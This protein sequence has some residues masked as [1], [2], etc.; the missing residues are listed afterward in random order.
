MEK[1]DI[2]SPNTLDSHFTLGYDIFDPEKHMSE[3]SYQIW[4]DKYGHNDS[5]PEDTFHRVAK[6]IAD[7]EE[8]EQL[9]SQQ[10]DRFFGLMRA[11][12]WSPAG[13][14]LAGAGTQKRVTLVNCFVNKTIED[15]MEDI[16]QANTEAAL[17]MQQG[18]GMGT[19]FSTIR[20]SGAV[21]KRTGSE[22]SGPLPFMDM[23][24]SMCGTIMSAGSRRGAM[25][26][27]LSDTHP[28]LLQ[29]IVAKQDLNRMTNFNVSILVSDAFMSAVKQDDDWY[30][31][32]EVPPINRNEDLI[33]LDFIDSK[34][35]QQYVYSK[36][37]ALDIF[38]TII[39]N[40][41]DWAE[42]GVIFIDKVNYWNNLS[43]L[44]NIRCTNPCGEQPLPPY[45]ACN[46]GAIN[47]ARLVRK[48]FQK[49]ASLNVGALCN[50]INTGM[51][52]LDN[53][54]DASLYPLEKQKQEQIDKRRT[55]L[56]YTGFADMCTQLG[57][58]Y[59][60]ERSLELADTVGLLLRDGAYQASVELAREKGSFKLFNSGE[61][62]KSPFVQQ[63]PETLKRAIQEI[64]I[65]NG[66]LLTLAP[67]GTT[68]IVY[69]NVSSSIEPN[70]M[71][72]Y[73]RNVKE[74]DG[75]W[76]T[77]TVTSYI[78]NFYEYTKQTVDNSLLQENIPFTTTDDLSVSEHVAVQATFQKYIDASISKT[79][80]CPKDMTFEDFK[81]VYLE[82]Y[83]QGCKGCTTYKPGKREAVL[84]SGEQ[85]LEDQ[86]KNAAQISKPIRENELEGV[87]YKIKWPTMQSALYMTI[88]HTIEGKPFEV[89]FNSKDARIYEWMTA[90]SLSLT[91]IFKSVDDPSFITKELKQVNSV[92]ESAWVDGKHFGSI[93]ALIAI[94]IEQHFERLG[95]IEN[96][97]VTTTEDKTVEQVKQN[98]YEFCVNCGQYQ[99][100]EQS[101]CN[102]CLNCGHSKCV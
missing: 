93:I 90:L 84:F 56:G 60:S 69:G 62:L 39:E 45:G 42:P 27:T 1:I 67:T 55:G 37:K 23:W 46:L 95:L 102:V 66:V 85:K 44:E 25:M 32:H 7:V 71:L 82:A 11:G 49:T 14:I 68:S 13:R 81:A 97:T 70:F 29:F 41:Y 88:N 20:P 52:F 28:D 26:G 17:T 15:C 47:L 74:K 34:G 63:L 38:N 101:G 72:E 51:R 77:S 54:I 9:R 73:Q 35:K 57:I 94:K 19:D 36:H 96:K 78:K 40:T 83:D 65:R 50:A 79:I 33:H 91:A 3:F 16:M 2:L 48:P 31:Y 58:A 86:T 24:S 12:I 80:N 6:A 75:S 76:R 98:E 92:L 87:T 30:L 53:V 61:Y 43:Y 59:G 4:K 21:L 8:T 64:G 10:Y 18:G 99:V 5:T 100:I 22:A 89:F